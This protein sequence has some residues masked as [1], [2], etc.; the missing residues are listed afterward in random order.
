MLSA[1][2][3]WR[4]KGALVVDAGDFFGGSAFHEYSRGRVEERLLGDLY[5]AVVPG[6]HDLADLVRLRAPGRFPPV[7]CA[8]LAPPPCF[9]GR[10]ETGIV[11]DARG[12][13]VGIVGFIGSQAFRSAPAGERA[14]YRFTEPTAALLA[15]ERDRL[16]AAG[17]DIVIGVSHS[18]FAADVGLHLADG[19]L[20]IIVASHCHS[21]ACH[22]AVPPRHV[23][24]PPECGTG[25]LAIT[26]D[27]GRDP[28]FSISY[29][30]PQAG[31]GHAPGYLA[32]A[33]S[34]YQ[35]WAA[36][37]VGMIAAEVADRRQL[38]DI[39]AGRG[40]AASGADAFF[41]NLASLRAGLPRHVDRQALAAAAPFDSGLVLL[42][43]SRQLDGILRQAEG[44]G[45]VP[46]TD[47]VLSGGAGVIAT[48][49]YMAERLGLPATQVSPPGSLRSLLTGFIREGS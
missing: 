34:A 29:P 13:R 45:E 2:R 43:G 4:G 7:V 35:A 36:E 47:S 16:L 3:D 17:A 11:L 6:N 5:D 38:A 12:L 22:W 14:G 23:V 10:W 48:T 19:P 8:N 46:V 21:P 15:A 30:R 20:D 41:F 49:A 28:E 18:G 32:D 9:C 39:L 44:L 31:S 37:P 1:V 24:K 25:L 40:R 26:L 27:A 33:V 42:S